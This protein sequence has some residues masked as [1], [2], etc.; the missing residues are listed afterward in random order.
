MAVGLQAADIAALQ[1]DDGKDQCIGG[2]EHHD[3]GHHA[4]Q[5]SPNASLFVL[6][7]ISLDHKDILDPHAGTSFPGGDLK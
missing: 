2:A 6:F 7:D 1:G 3:A 4:D 5:L